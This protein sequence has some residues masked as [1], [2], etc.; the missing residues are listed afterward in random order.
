M[1]TCFVGSLRFLTSQDLPG[2]IL[3]VFPSLDQLSGGSGTG[4]LE[5]SEWFPAHRF[6]TLV[7]F[8]LPPA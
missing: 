2:K 7:Q 8:T 1:G 4:E 3:T 5:I 6:E